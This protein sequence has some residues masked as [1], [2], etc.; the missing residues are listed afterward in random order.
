MGQAP[1]SGGAQPGESRSHAGVARRADRRD[2]Q[3]GARTSVY[4]ASSD[5]VGRV[6]GKYFEK[7]RPVESAPASHD[8]ESMRRLWEVSAGMTGLPVGD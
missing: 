7:C 8:A 6:S 1:A 2:V 5:E 4:L 3:E